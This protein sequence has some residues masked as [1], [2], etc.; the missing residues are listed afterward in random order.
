MVSLL[1][2]DLGSLSLRGIDEL[3]LLDLLGLEVGLLLVELGLDGLDLLDG[4]GVGA[5][6]LICVVDA[7][8]EIGC[9]GGAHHE[10]D[11]GDAAGLVVGRDAV[12]QGGLGC[13]E[14]VLLLGDLLLGGGDLGLGVLELGLVVLKLLEGGSGLLLIGCALGLRLVELSLELRRGGGEGRNG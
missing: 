7:A 5:G 6:H 9:G 1:L 13:V 8:H 2:L 12:G 11:D 3:L 4:L 10:V 14:L